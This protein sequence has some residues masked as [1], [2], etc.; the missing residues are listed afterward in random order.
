VAWPP[1][2]GALAR[3][4]S[5]ADRLES[6]SATPA[7]CGPFPFGAAVPI[8]A[9]CAIRWNL[10]TR[11][12]VRSA[13]DRRSSDF[14]HFVL[15]DAPMSTS[16]VGFLAATRLR[17]TTAKNL[18]LPSPRM[19]D[20]S[21]RNTFAPT[22]RALFPLPRSG[23]RRAFSVALRPRLYLVGHPVATRRS[24]APWGLT[25]QSLFLSL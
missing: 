18:T 7:L 15:D 16:A 3:H 21:L 2:A 12:R 13:G 4:S 10:I 9:A 11:S 5:W 24:A 22:G 1:Y 6:R 25:G 14:G 23:V 19:T 20:R 8:F 17:L